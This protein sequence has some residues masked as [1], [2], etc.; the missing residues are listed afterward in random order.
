MCVSLAERLGPRLGGRL[1]GRPRIGGDSCGEC[2]RP[3]T[4]LASLPPSSARMILVASSSVMP[5]LVALTTGAAGA[6]TM[7]ERCVAALHTRGWEGDEELATQ[8]DTARGAAPDPQVTQIPVGLDFLADVLEG[9]PD[10]AGAR[11]D[12]VSGEVWPESVLNEAWPGDEDELENEDRWL[13]VDPMGSG[14]AYRDVIDLIAT[15]R[16]P[17]L[18]ARL[19]AAVDGR[20]AFRRFRSTLDDWPQDRLDWI[21]FLRRA[22]ARTGT[23]MAHQRGLSTRGSTQ[24][25]ATRPRLG[26]GRRRTCPRG[27][28]AT[29][30][31]DS[32]DRSVAESPVAASTEV[33]TCRT[34]TTNS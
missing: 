28:R 23:R 34:C 17:G 31:N 11:V 25:V 22:P 15:R 14:S 6:S 21:E 9:G 18:R 30:R 16:S 3:A 13:Y 10:S 33:G 2:W 1:F 7:A 5:L 24:R 27:G 19:E 32:G 29:V 4:A 26:T 12:L 8:L 20:G